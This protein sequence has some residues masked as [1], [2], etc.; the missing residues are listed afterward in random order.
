M[1]YI[2]LID[3]WDLFMDSKEIKFSCPV[4]SKEGKLTFVNSNFHSCTST[5]CVTWD[6]WRSCWGK[7]LSKI[8]V[9]K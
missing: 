9:E 6:D 8:S 7:A 3:A 4:F 5:K 2:T 1:K